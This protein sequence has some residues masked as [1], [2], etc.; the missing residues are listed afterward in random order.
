MDDWPDVDDAEAIEAWIQAQLEA[1]PVPTPRKRASPATLALA[2]GAADSAARPE[3]VVTD[4]SVAT[5]HGESAM[6]DAPLTTRTSA[7]HPA[8]P[9]LGWRS[10]SQRLAHAPSA[11]VDPDTDDPDDIDSP[12]YLERK[13]QIL[14]AERAASLSDDNVKRNAG[15][16]P[17]HRPS[18]SVSHDQHL[19]SAAVA[20]Q[21]RRPWE[22]LVREF[23]TKSQQLAEAHHAALQELAAT[24]L[25][26]PILAWGEPAQ[27]DEANQPARNEATPDTSSDLP[28][29]P[30]SASHTGNSAAD[31]GQPSASGLNLNPAPHPQA[32]P[33]QQ[34][35]QAAAKLQARLAE[36][37]K[38][39]QASQQAR[40]L[41]S[42]RVLQRVFTAW[43]AR[44]LWRPRLHAAHV[45][46]QAQQARAA[47]R[48]QAL[49]RGWL[50]RRRYSSAIA[51][52]IQRTR[53]KSKLLQ[54]WCHSGLDAAHRGLA[55]H[56]RAQEEQAERQRLEAERQA[57]LQAHRRQEE[58]A[59]RLAAQRAAEEARLAEE[60]AKRQAAQ[61]AHEAQLQRAEQAL[62]QL[63]LARQQ[64]SPRLLDALHAVTAPPRDVFAD[65]PASHVTLRTPTSEHAPTMRILSSGG[66]W[67]H[68]PGFTS[69]LS[70]LR[71]QGCNLSTIPELAA[72]PLLT[73]L[74]VSHNKLASINVHHLPW[75]TY[76]NVA[77]NDLT[78]LEVIET[79][80]LRLLDC[81]R[82]QLTTFPTWPAPLAQLQHLDVSHNQ[83]QDLGGILS[84]VAPGLRR[85][86]ALDNPLQKLTV[87]DIP[88]LTTATISVETWGTAVGVDEAERWRIVSGD[89]A[90]MMI[91]LPRLAP[92]HP[93]WAKLEAAAPLVELNP[94]QTLVQ[95]DGSVAEL[96]AALRRWLA[97]TN[98]HAV[99]P[100]DLDALWPLAPNRRKHVAATRIQAAWR[101]H[102]LRRHLDAIL[103]NVFAVNAGASNEHGED[104]QVLRFN[105]PDASDLLD[106]ERAPRKTSGP[107]M[108]R[109][110]VRTGNVTPA[111][112]RAEAAVSQATE[113]VPLPAPD[114][115]MQPMSATSRPRS[116]QDLPPVRASRDAPPNHDATTR[117]LPPEASDRAALLYTQRQKSARAQHHKRRST[118]TWK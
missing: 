71:L 108:S 61:R 116:A 74:D 73:Y 41:A 83:L 64:S 62:T 113:P 34:S 104:D 93:A 54:T 90:K 55:A 70:V 26:T 76:M 75:L 65:D 31:E 21:D 72:L 78:A 1:L 23:V 84:H 103:H 20:P 69:H 9:R 47:T 42:A 38:T 51:T 96:L 10:I 106:L 67:S 37:E 66:R 27:D 3:G 29:S 13:V 112:A 59:A 109:S 36:L 102:H 8:T 101:G 7:L 82:N 111:D 117:S 30:A 94:L 40:Q 50:C 24:T 95:T 92:E 100:K 25:P 22:L 77:H 81:S 118:S 85:L 49:V 53:A 44:D 5:G 43:C 11:P 56:H 60:R 97:L 115:W 28:A 105:E 58:E 57:A 52:A 6:M 79:P 114:R 89:R 110:K 87:D 16:P 68:F 15:P 17:P 14:R 80:S 19:D 107:T 88:V 63:E 4:A 35:R 91:T 18:S 32:Q 86:V 39:R 98:S 33:A 12:A 99:Q 46:Y 48:L 2:T 45:Q